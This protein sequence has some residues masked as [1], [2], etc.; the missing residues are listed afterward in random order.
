MEKALSRDF[1]HPAISFQEF[2][3]SSNPLTEGSRPHAGTTVSGSL[4]RGCT[5]KRSVAFEMGCAPPHLQPPGWDLPSFCL[6]DT[7][8]LQELSPGFAG[9]CKNLLFEQLREPNV[10]ALKGRAFLGCRFLM[11]ALGYECVIISLLFLTA[12]RPVGLS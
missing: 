8:A 2:C 10:S 6:T 5:P 4:L 1:W 12:W 11:K 9:S 3:F 7:C